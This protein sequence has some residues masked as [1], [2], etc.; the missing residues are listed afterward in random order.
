[1]R[2]YWEPGHFRTSL[3]EKIIDRLYGRESAF[4][5]DLTPATID[6]VLAAI[7]HE[8]DQALAEQ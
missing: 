1:M 7:R 2:W 4:G 3:G 6:T 8:R 5:R